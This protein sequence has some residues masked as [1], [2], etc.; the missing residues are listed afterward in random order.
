[1][2]WVEKTPQQDPTWAMH[3]PNSISFISPCFKIDLSI[4][5]FLAYTLTWQ[6][7]AKKREE[8]T[9]SKFCY[10]FFFL[11]KKFCYFLNNKE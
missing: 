1:M 2:D 8:E 4:L 10:Y 9:N 6:N 11:G 7:F 5:D 3:T